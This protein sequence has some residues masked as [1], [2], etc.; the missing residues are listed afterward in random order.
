MLNRLE[1]AYLDLFFQLQQQ[2]WENYAHDAGMSS[3]L[4]P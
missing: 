2:Q 3:G 1:Q 4:H